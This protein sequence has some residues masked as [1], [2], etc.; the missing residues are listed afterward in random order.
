MP[1]A[2][3]LPDPVE[4]IDNA[5][6]PLQGAQRVS[7]TSYQC[8]MERRMTAMLDEIWPGLDNKL[9][10]FCFISRH[11]NRCYNSYF[12]FLMWRDIKLAEYPGAYVRVRNWQRANTR[13]KG[14]FQQLD[15]IRD[16]FALHLAQGTHTP[17][18]CDSGQ[19]PSGVW[20]IY[21]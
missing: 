18:G 5:G 4:Y 1:V 12:A 11:F 9:L 14:V 2:D 21:W 17:S 15:N 13:E 6:P 10:L 3:F 7:R 16:N 20:L 8:R 19:V